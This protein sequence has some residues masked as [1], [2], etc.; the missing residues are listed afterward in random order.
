MAEVDVSTEILDNIRKDFMTGVKNDAGIAKLSTK[1]GKGKGTQKDMAALSDRLG[2]QASKALK[3]NLKLSDLPN[4]TLYWNIA[5]K[6]IR[7]L[8][9]SVYDQ[10]NHYAALQLK[11]ADRVSKINISILRGQDPAERIRQAMNMAVNSLTQPELDNALTDPVITS[12]RKFYDDFQMRNAGFRESMGFRSVIVREYDG[13]GLHNGRD[14]CEW[15]ISR[16]GT[17]DYSTA[18]ENGV[19]ERHPGCGCSIVHFTERGTTNVQTNWT[20]NE[21][22]ES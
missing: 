20:R 4:E 16:A 2:L 14:A 11:G 3:A 22:Q 15:C 9:D 21:W 8:L 19:F 1:I 10:I 17:Y 7:P 18:K 5:D 13:V 6:T 12:A